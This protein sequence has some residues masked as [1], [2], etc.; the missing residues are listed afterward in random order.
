MKRKV[1]TRCSSE[2]QQSIIRVILFAEGPGE[3]PQV[4][5]SQ[6]NKLLLPNTT[7]HFVQVWNIIPIQLAFDQV[8]HIIPI[9]PGIW[10]GLKYHPAKDFQD[11]N[12]D[13][14][15]FH[16]CETA[17][18]NFPFC[19]LGKL[20]V[21]AI[22]LRVPSDLDLIIGL[23]ALEGPRED[24]ENRDQST[25]YLDRQAEG[26]SDEGQDQDRLAQRSPWGRKQG[27]RC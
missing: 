10:S 23:S 6:V 4:R 19:T 7:R 24:L 1:T 26:G 13:V 25:F 8:W 5:F 22:T 9:Q 15:T 16:P 12:Q 20:S 3:I 21:K 18:S 14:N 27:W 17:Q 11:C 2:M